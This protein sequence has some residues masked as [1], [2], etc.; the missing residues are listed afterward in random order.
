MIREDNKKGM[1]D[2]LKIAKGFL[3][4]VLLLIVARLTLPLFIVKNPASI[5]L[6]IVTLIIIFDTAR[7]ETK[8]LRSY[9]STFVI[10][11]LIVQI[12]FFLGRFGVLGFFLIVGGLVVW[13]LVKGWA[14]F[15]SGVR[16][17]ETKI[18]GAPL[19]RKNHSQK[20]SKVKR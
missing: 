14:Y 2:D 17:I 5:S 6:W 1:K 18:W 8:D 7:R 3:P 12:I 11:F 19:D 13:R 4:I 10:L 20:K 9:L 15:M 16:K